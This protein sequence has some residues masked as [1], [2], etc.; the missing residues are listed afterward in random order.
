MDM[1]SMVATGVSAAAVHTARAKLES[2]LACLDDLDFPE[3]AL[4]VSLALD[5]LNERFPQPTRAGSD[6]PEGTQAGHAGNRY[7]EVVV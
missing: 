7:D 1:L 3:A 5:R 2:T 6:H 4:H